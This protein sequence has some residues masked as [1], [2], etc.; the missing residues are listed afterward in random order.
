[1]VSIQPVCDL[2]M[3]FD[4]CRRS[5]RPRYHRPLL[6]SNPDAPLLDMKR[7]FG[8]EGVGFGANT[9]IPDQRLNDLFKKIPARM[10]LQ[11]AIIEFMFD[12]PT[13][14]SFGCA[15]NEMR[16]CADVTFKTGAL[17]ATAFRI[18]VLDSTRVKFSRDSD[19]A[20]LFVINGIFYCQGPSL[21]G[22][23]NSDIFRL[24]SGSNGGEPIDLDNTNF[25]D[26]LRRFYTLSSVGS[27]WPL[28]TISG[29]WQSLGSCRVPLA[30]PIMVFVRPGNG[31]TRML[32]ILSDKKEMAKCCMGLNEI[33][34]K[35]Y[36]DA[37]AVSKYSQYCDLF[38]KS[39]CVDHPDDEFCGCYDEN[40]YKEFQALPAEL[41]TAKYEPI[42]KANPRCWVKGCTTGYIPYN[43]RD[44]GGCKITICDLNQTIVGE[45]Y[46]KNVSGEIMCDGGVPITKPTT[47]PPATNLPPSNPPPS[48]PP[49]SNLPPSN[50]PPT[51]VPPSNLPPN[52]VPPSNPP[53]T[54]SKEETSLPWIWILFIIL[55]ILFVALGIVISLKKKIKVEENAMQQT[56]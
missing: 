4:N 5:S 36:C 18:S 7:L 56:S 33:S 55:I 47:N 34:D 44:Q 11:G 1:M 16:V 30:R 23:I 14:F 15:A 9:E 40:V 50:L 42:L 46:V 20:P 51:T 21:T 35:P 52:T 19:S 26:F 6:R 38:M 22:G 13:N 54:Y 25:Y 43:Y 24:A 28:C 31:L 8:I 37:L 27:G 17:N 45:N 2:A 29:I 3:G 41:K 48:N 49:P 53:T 10:A 12:H 39:F 32:Q